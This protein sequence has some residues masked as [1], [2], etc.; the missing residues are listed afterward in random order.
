ML[1]AEKSQLRSLRYGTGSD[2]MVIPYRNGANTVSA[3]KAE[4][5][6]VDSRK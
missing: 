3:D 5:E 2:W 4:E 1:D 6:D